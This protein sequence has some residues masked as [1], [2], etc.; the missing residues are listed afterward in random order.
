MSFG[1]IIPAKIAASNNAATQVLADTNLDEFSEQG[2][3]APYTFQIATLNNQALL[4][5]LGKTSEC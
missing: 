5:K 2:T 1:Y 3:Y 4:N